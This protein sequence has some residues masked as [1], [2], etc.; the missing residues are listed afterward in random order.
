MRG[1]EE[2]DTLKRGIERGNQNS[3]EETLDDSDEDEDE[4]GRGTLEDMS[5]L[6]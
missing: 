2:G 6:V 1:R 4:D 3:N 5:C